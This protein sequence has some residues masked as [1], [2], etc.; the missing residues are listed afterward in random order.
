M[1]KLEDLI[2]TYENFPQSGIFFKDLLGILQDP[3]VFKEL[4]YKMS[5][6]QIIKKC[7]A[8]AS[9]DARGF[10]FGS[11]ISIFSS[12]PMVVLRKPGKLPGEL[13]TASYEL[14]YG[15]N[16]LTIQKDSVKSF[17]SFDLIIKLSNLGI[18]L[19]FFIM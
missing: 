15:K 6:N 13:I 1:K 11:P 8:I 19:N 9:I 12:K 17:K 4:I 2:Q 14:E 5:D 16:S 10:I 3:K 7:D 18:T